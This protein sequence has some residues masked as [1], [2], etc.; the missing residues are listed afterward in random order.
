MTDVAVVVL[1]AVVAFFMIMAAIFHWV[2][3]QRTGEIFFDSMAHVALHPGNHLNIIL[4]E[5]V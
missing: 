1:A 2:I 4:G 3:A 5:C